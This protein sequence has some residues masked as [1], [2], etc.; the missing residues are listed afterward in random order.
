MNGRAE[1]MLRRALDAEAASV[2]VS[3]DALAVIRGRVAARG[4]RGWATRRGGIMITIGTG[5]ATAL[6]A[7]TVAVLAGTGAC[8]PP[9]TRHP[10]PATAPGG[11]TATTPGGPTATP[12]TASP[13]TVPVKPPGTGSAPAPGGSPTPSA[14]LVNLP[15]YYVG[16]TRL[17]LRLFRE[18]HQ[19]AV[20]QV[21]AAQVRVAVSE[22]LLRS[23]YDP[24]YSS[25]WPAG[26]AV[27]AVSV[28]GGSVTVDL[29]GARTNPVDP[30][31]ARA[32]L[33][34]LVWTATAV[35]GAGNVYLLLDGAPATTLWGVPAS[36][37]LRRAAAADTL[38]PIWL[39]DPQQGATVARTFTVHVAG[40]V[41]EAQGNLRI[42]AANGQVVLERAVSF[43]QA[44][45]AQGE[46]SVTVTLPAGTPAGRY[47]VT[48]YDVSERD[49]TVID[50]D[51]HEISVR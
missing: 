18:Y 19:L 10:A 6:V 45:P 2:V 11:A 37:A 16:S 21:K 12:A 32:A 28:S 5:T 46:A 22:M 43:S 9:A 4:L 15:V 25:P 44:A 14:G 47:T 24:D 38:A 26:A 35:S 34:Q 20:G 23:A 1:D 36:G 30:A 17:G 7:A 40:F 29:S 49:G 33:A 31:T 39:I 8:Q 27:R 41:F 3:T 42:T 13:G 48:G 51:N 50:A